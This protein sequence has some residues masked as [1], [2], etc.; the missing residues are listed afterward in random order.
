MLPA[1]E[2]G[3]SVHALRVRVATSLLYG[4]TESQRY[5]ALA[6]EDPIA[7]PWIRAHLDRLSEVLDEVRQEQPAEAVPALAS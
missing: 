3:E 5:S 1:A 4:E 7:L 6:A 2:F